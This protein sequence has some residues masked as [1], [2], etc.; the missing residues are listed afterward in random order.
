MGDILIWCT[1]GSTPQLGAQIPTTNVIV[2]IAPSVPITSRIIDPAGNGISEAMLIVDEAGSNIT[3]GATGGYGPQAPQSLCTTA[4]QQNPGGSACTAQVGLDNSGQYYVAVV[5][6]TSTPAQNV[7]QGKVGDFGANSV[8]F[9]NVPVLAPAY[10]GLSET[11]RIT[12]IRIPIPG[13]NLT[14]TAQAIISTSPSQIM[15][16]AGTAINVGVVGPAMMASVDASPA[17]GGNPFPTCVPQT[18]RTLAAKIT[19]TEGFATGFHTRVVPGVAANDV[20]GNGT[21]NTTWAA[22]AQN[23]ASPANQN[24]P[25]D[26]Y[27]AFAWNQESGFIL[28]AA[29]FTDATSNITYTA[30]LADFG[31]RLKA[32]FSFIPA[33]VTVYVSTTNAA[34]YTIPGGTNTAPYAVLVADSQSNEANGDGATFTPLTSAIAGSDGLLAYPLTADNSGGTAAVW[35]VLNANPGALDVLTFSVYIAYDST[36]GTSMPPS[37]ALSYAPEPGGGSFPTVNATSGLSGPM[38]RFGVVRSQGGPFTTI[39]GC[40]VSPGS[41]PAPFNYAIG[42][43]APSSQTVPVTVSPSNLPVT[44]TPVVS[45]PASGTWLSASLT[46]GTLTISV[47]PWGLAASSTAYT[48]YVKLSASGISDILVPVT[49]NVY[50]Q[51]ALSIIK[52]HSGNFGAGQLGATYTLTVSNGPSAGPTSGPVIV[53]EN[54]P[55]GMSVVSMTSTGNVW[56]CTTTTCTANTSLPGGDSYPPITVSVN[57]ASSTTSPL[58]NQATVSGG[59]STA[60]STANDST[61]VMLTCTVTGDLTPSVA[62][63]QMLINQA[64]GVAPLTYDFNS[65][66]MVNVADVQV[67]VNAAMG[68]GCQ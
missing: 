61:N 12:N 47:N 56:S 46:G 26:M 17:G 63:V 52:T 9:Y 20:P 28:P 13:G 43:T 48:G 16:V 59:G 3:T 15:P 67:V 57:V 38:P 1:G 37:V 27:G 34:S 29:A 35:E 65:D 10:Q 8:T 55:S 50:P 58:T 22:E 60:V 49:L 19:F 25:G 23:L 5:P 14:G 40:Q 32:V 41:S 44:A 31:S 21:A 53:T 39:T 54:P 7:F 45:T 66:G 18:N 6:G 2:Y 42:G 24:I 62:D 51:P 33:G 4:Q 36:L 68:H 64:L 11:F 30:G